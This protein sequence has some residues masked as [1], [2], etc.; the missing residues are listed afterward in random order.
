MKSIG[1]MLKSI[2]GLAYTKDATEWESEFIESVAEQ[3][4]KNNGATNK[5]TDRQVLIVER[6][7]KK[8]FV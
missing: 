6:I 8:N 2:E 3:V 1:A 5:L 7:Y 4:K